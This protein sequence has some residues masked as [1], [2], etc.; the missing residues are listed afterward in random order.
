MQR[1]IPCFNFGD[2][3]KPFVQQGVFRRHQSVYE[4]G[5]RTRGVGP[6]VW[7]NDL[8]CCVEAISQVVGTASVTKFGYDKN[9]KP[10]LTKEPKMLLNDNEAGKPEGIYLM[11]GRV[12][13][14]A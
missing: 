1:S 5:D 13:Y 12:P 4:R 3:H 11:I 8:A 7:K 2:A 14:A 6:G 10:F 9:G